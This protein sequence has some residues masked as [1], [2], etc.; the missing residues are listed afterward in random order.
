MA[1][2]FPRL[3]R[4]LCGGGANTKKES[5]GS[6]PSLKKTIKSE[7]SCS[8]TV[9]K[10][11]KG[12]IGRGGEEEKMGNVV[13]PEPD[14]PEWSIGWVEPHGP[15]FK[16]ED[17]TGGGFVVL[18]PCYKKVMGGSGN[19]I[20]N[21]FFSTAPVKFVDGKNMEQLLSSIRKL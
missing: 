10:A 7:S 3:P 6:P 13:F 12:W 20:L 9:K 11:K 14:D 15:G 16:S 4:W 21:G 18:V 1:V 17:D 8:T 5:K 2:S 19:Q